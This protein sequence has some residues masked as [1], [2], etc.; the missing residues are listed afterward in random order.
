MLGVRLV[1]DICAR[2]AAVG[3]LIVVGRTQYSGQPIGKTIQALYRFGVVLAANTTTQQVFGQLPA[4]NP[5]EQAL[6]SQLAPRSAVDQH[7]RSP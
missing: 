7:T 5:S 3:C 6:A 2:P 1:G 4:G